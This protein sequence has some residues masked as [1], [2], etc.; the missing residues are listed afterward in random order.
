MARF[1]HYVVVQD[2]DL[3]LFEEFR[4]C[5][6]L[7]LL[8]TKDVLPE[9]VER[10]REFARKFAG[11]LGRRFTKIA[12]SS[13]R[14]FSWPDWPSY[15]GW[16][17]QQLCK[18]KLASELDCDKAVVLDSDVVVTPHANPKD[19]YADSGVV[20]FAQ[21]ACRASIRGKV[22]HWLEESE[23]L[24][25][26]RP[27]S[28][29]VNVY[30]DTPFVFDKKLLVEALNE[31]ESNYGK[32]W[33]SELLARPPRRWSEFG[34]Y[35]AFLASKD[36]QINLE[37][38]EPTFFRYLYDTRNPET[39]VDQVRTFMKDAQV[40]YVTI[41]SQASGRHEWPANDFLKPI[42]SDLNVGT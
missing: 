17:T 29:L 25:G 11:N 42:L 6:G 40:H 39:V 19:F 10:R 12:G 2:E 22:K 1:H 24:V 36:S 32:P 3:Y 35:K 41:H 18:L 15:T 37:W 30:F 13:K 8:S 34:Y 14:M 21:W 27:D 33:W 38:R 23:G 7:T 26:V 20:C 31:L 28:G 5:S 16:H 4:Q 9:D